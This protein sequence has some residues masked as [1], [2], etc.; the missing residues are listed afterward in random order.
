MKDEETGGEY[1]MHGKGEKNRRDDT[2]WET[3]I[4]WLRIR[5]SGGILWIR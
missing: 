3:W 2:I 5:C 1:N 4:T